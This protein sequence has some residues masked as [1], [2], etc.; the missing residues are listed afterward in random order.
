MEMELLATSSPSTALC[1]WLGLLMS[2]QLLPNYTREVFTASHAMVEDTGFVLLV[3][4][5][6]QGAN[7]RCRTP[8]LASEEK[9]RNKKQKQVRWVER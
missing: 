4:S 6:E 7:A 5:L 8:I 9:M 3:P 2:L 1:C